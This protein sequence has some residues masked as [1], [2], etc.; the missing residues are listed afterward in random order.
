MNATVSSVVPQSRERYRA[1]FHAQ[2]LPMGALTAWR[3]AALERFLDSG[4]PTQRDEAWKYTNLR[5]LETRSFGRAD[6]APAVQ[7]VA[8]REELQ[9]MTAA[10]MRTVLL[11]GRW[12]PQLSG[13]LPQPPG[14]TVLALGQWLQHAPEQAAEF[15]QRH[16]PRSAAFEHLNQAFGND[17]IV[18]ELADDTVCDLPLYL[19]HHWS[20]PGLMSHPRI[21]VRVGRNSRCTLIEHYTGTAPDTFTNAVTTIEAASGAQL[22]HYRV[23]HE[24]AQTFHIGHTHVDLAADATYTQYELALGA[25][26]SRVATHVALR[27]RGATATL[28]GLIMPNGSQHLDTFTC[29]E[30]VAGHTTS[31]ELYRGIAAGRGRAVFR[32]KVIVRPDAQHIDAQQSTRNLL[33][34]PTAEIDTRPE[35][36]IYANDVKCSHGATIGQLDAAALFYL[37]SRGLSESDARTVLIRAFAEGFVSQLQHAPVAQFLEQQLAQRFANL[38]EAS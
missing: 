1:L 10:S 6:T 36:E 11:N 18:I 24:A 27:G 3:T 38:T 4:F 28:Q 37:R 22:V 12:A 7:S 8:S 14:V 5:R 30:H 17:G 34:S 21:I 19:I 9:W 13:T 15:L 2:Q 16:A 35:L 25:A 29:I 20:V 23:Q 26:L 33:L 31:H 32:G